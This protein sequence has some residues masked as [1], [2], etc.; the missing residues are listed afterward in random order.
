MKRNFE[1]ELLINM[2]VF[3]IFVPESSIKELRGQL[4]T[5]KKRALQEKRHSEQEKLKQINEIKKK[6]WC[7]HCGKEAL[8]Y[9]CWNTSYCDYDCQVTLPFSALLDQG[10]CLTGFSI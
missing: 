9:C 8:F 7:A 10:F 2:N 5:E 1:F 6:Q 4:E 3:C